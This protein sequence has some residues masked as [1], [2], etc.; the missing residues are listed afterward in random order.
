ML[1]P[2]TTFAP[3]NGD[4]ATQTTKLKLRQNGRV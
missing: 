4:P 2:K 3:F 1:L